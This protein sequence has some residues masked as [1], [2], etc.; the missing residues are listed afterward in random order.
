VNNFNAYGFNLMF[1]IVGKF[2]GVYRNPVFNYPTWVGNNKTNVSSF[3][4][5]VFNGDPNIPGFPKY[6]ETQ[7]YLW[8]RYAPNLQGLVESSS[9]VE[10]KEID[11]EYNFSS[12][13]I[14]KLQLNNLRLFAQVRDLGMLWHANSK[15]YNP[16]W[17]PGTQRPVT[18]YTFGLNVKF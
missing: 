13:I 9:F 17:L 18:S 15:G 1:V 14:Q 8:D 2:G 12:S 7:F 4:S 16:E 3:V 10:L 5:D 6:Q 11:L